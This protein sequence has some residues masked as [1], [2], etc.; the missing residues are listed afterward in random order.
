MK[1]S[2]NKYFIAKAML[3]I[4]CL[5]GV[6]AFAANNNTISHAFSFARPDVKVQISGNVQRN[7]QSIS[8]DKAVA[9]NSG[10]I[11]DW[12]IDSANEGAGDAQHYRVV[13]QISKGTVFV[14]G[15]A[16]GEQAP[17]VTYSIDNGKTFSAQ[18]MIDEKQA[19]GTTK[20]VAAPVSMYSQVMFEWAQPLV[21]QAKLNANYRVRVN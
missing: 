15:T 6:V 7:N 5:S 2:M 19:D 12:N 3:A 17:Q 11:L 10:E 18:P 1:R 20:K 21:A 14:A 9:V 16:R 8:L 4:F 13:G